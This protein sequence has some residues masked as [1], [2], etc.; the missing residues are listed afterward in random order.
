MLR[1]LF[2][3]LIFP[4]VIF[5][6]ENI[7]AR[8]FALKSYVAVANDIWTIFYNPAGIS[9][10]KNR[11][12]SISYIPAQF[13]IPELSK[14]GIAYFEPSLSVKFG[15]GAQV[16]GFSLYKETTLKFS[17]AKSFD[18]FDIGVNLNY[19]LVSI[20]SYGNAGAFSADFGIISNPLKFL[21]FGFVFKNIIATKLGQ[22]RE[23]LPK[24]FDFGI[25]VLP[26]E[27][28]IVSAQVDKEI[29]FRES[30]KYGV[31]YVIENFLFLRFGL[32]NYP[33]QYSGGVGLKIFLLQIDY[34]INQHQ[35]LGLTHQ[36]TFSAKL[37][38]SR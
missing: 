32:T 30:F 25:A 16:F 33:V 15:V 5:S 38:K 24:E 13:E 22:A 31:E 35:L 28:L 27:S 12:I 3:L 6:Q 7:G 1:F 17:L 19:N 2:L 36:L 11:E 20:K 21:K 37:G 14:K 23:R 18:L 10:L 4:M 8:A 9:N 26:Y 34:S 29:Y